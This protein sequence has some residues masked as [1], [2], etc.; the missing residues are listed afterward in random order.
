MKRNNENHSRRGALL[1]ACM[2]G[3]GTI[4]SSCE[5]FLDIDEYIYDRTTIDSVFVSKLK[6]MEY[7]NG[8]AAFLPNEGLLYRDESTTPGASASDEFIYSWK[9]ATMLFLL[10]E[11][12]PESW[13]YSGTWSNMYKGIRKANIILARMNE[14]K[15]LTD[16][17]RR[18]YM[19]RAYFL[20]AYFYYTL[21]R[22]YG[23]VPIL[24]DEAFDTD[25]AAA[26]VAQERDT[27]D[28]CVEYICENMEQ[29]ATYLPAQ[30]DRAFQFVPT[31]GGALSIIA[32]LRLYQASPW[33]NGNTRYSGWTRTDGRPFISQENDPERWAVAAAAFKRIIETNVYSLHT[34]E[35]TASTLPLPA[36]VSDAAFPD[37]AGNIDPYLSYKRIFDGDV[38]P[39]LNP[40]LILYCPADHAISR[41]LAPAYQNGENSFNIPLAFIESYRMADGR[42]Y[43]NATEA[44]R[45]W[46]NI[47]QAY[48]FSDEYVVGAGV[49]YRD[50]YREPRFYASIGYNHCIWPGTSYLGTRP[51]TNIEVTYYK[52][53][54]GA[55]AGD[56]NHYNRTGYTSRK[57]FHQEDCYADWDWSRC[58]SK[59]VPMVRYAEILLGYV[60]A[61]N[62]M[63]GTYTDPDTDIT[64][65]R[66]V[67]E[68]VRYFNMIRYRAGMPGITDADAGDQ[69][70]MRE[71]IR[72]ERKIELAFEGHRYYDLRRWG[73]AQ[74]YIGTSIYGYN[75]DANTSDRQRFYTP[76]I[77]DKEEIYRRTFNQKMYFYPIPKNTIERNRKLVQNPGWR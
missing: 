44:E 61:M 13:E 40:E 73:I 4:F 17:E 48:R 20:R 5:N 14:C 55:A 45:S 76:I 53:G 25:E 28:D 22:H 7:M 66:N 24:P 46:E 30:R 15:D 38:Q 49:A 54:T 37:G 35:R 11:I 71:L 31:K 63:N 27:W 60:E 21:V 75:V 16:F 43:R 6:L 47:G 29:A 56:A 36:T 8:T 18:D 70:R 69:N 42:E 68:M 59:T 41:M 19:G 10:D 1:V 67:A 3:F 12:T 52:D 77:L 33:Y 39:S 23:P 51:L 65:T 50:A 32:R 58:R 2:I 64:V 74:E 26:N 72:E 62:E 9:N 34:I 57:F